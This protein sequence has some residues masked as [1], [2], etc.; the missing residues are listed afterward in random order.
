MEMSVLEDV[1]SE[2]AS[3]SRLA[4]RLVEGEQFSAL[5]LVEVKAE[6]GLITFAIVEHE[7]RQFKI[8]VVE[9][10]NAMMKVSVESIKF[11]NMKIPLPTPAYVKMGENTP[12][13]EDLC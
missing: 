5:E 2:L 7:N 13:G 12:W 6:D 8:F 1:S 9:P 3:L 10:D 4:A 11:D